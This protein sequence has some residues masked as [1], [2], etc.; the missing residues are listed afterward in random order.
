MTQRAERSRFPEK[1]NCQTSFDHLPVAKSDRSLSEARDIRIV[2]HQDQRRAGGPIQF[3]HHLDHFRARLG[4]EI[5]GWF[6]GKKNLGPI[7]EGAGE[8]D[9]LLFA[10]RKLQRIV[11]APISEAH[12]LD[13]FKP[14]LAR[15]AVSPQLERHGHIFERGQRW[16]ELEI[17]KNEAD[18]LIANS[19]PFIFIDLAEHNAIQ[20]NEPGGR[21]IEPGGQP[22][23][24]GL[25]TSRWTQNGAGRAGFERKGDRAQ[26]RQRAGCRRVAFR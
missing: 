10:A 18:R 9:P 12:A 24:S 26:D 22:K 14:E 11:I 19:R 4:I 1:R 13:H 8:R 7:D 21:Q 3:K 25:P 16:N 20:P 17:L 6:I 23:Q 2:G 15:L 5:S